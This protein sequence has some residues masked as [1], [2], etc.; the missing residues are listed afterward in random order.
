[1]QDY[2]YDTPTPPSPLQKHPLVLATGQNGDG[3]EVLFRQRPVLGK[4]IQTHVYAVFT[5]TVS[6]YLH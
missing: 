1:M 3:T 5:E 2:N 6:L 4:V